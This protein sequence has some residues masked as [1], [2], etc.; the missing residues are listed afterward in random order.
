MMKNITNNQV[1]LRGTIVAETVTSRGLGVTLATNRVTSNNNHISDYI[2]IWFEDD[3]IEEY[4]KSKAVL[5]DR[6]EVVCQVF[7]KR[8]Y[9]KKYNS[10][11][12]TQFILAKS[13]RVEDKFNKSSADDLNDFILKG[14]LEKINKSE[15][16]CIVTLDL[17]GGEDIVNYPQA[18]TFNWIPKDI[19]VGDT[20]VVRGGVQSSRKRY[21]TSNRKSYSQMFIANKIQKAN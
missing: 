4:K 15:K 6:I 9:S 7:S 19:K 13:I 18:F 8:I 16:G 10:R 14:K 20:V 21:G 17:G 5:Y 3:M 11:S 2:L 1:L 12:Y